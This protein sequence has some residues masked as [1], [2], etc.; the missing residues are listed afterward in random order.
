MAFFFE[1]FISYGGQGGNSAYHHLNYSRYGMVKSRYSHITEC[2]ALAD[3][4]DNFMRCSETKI[5]DDYFSKYRNTQ[6]SG[7]RWIFS[8]RRKRNTG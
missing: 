2:L 1:I 4:M 5:K 6:F 3:K 7:S 8:I